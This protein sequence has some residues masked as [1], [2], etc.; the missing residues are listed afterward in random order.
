ME[1]TGRGTRQRAVWTTIDDHAAGAA[2]AFA[3]VMLKGHR[4]FTR[5]DQLFVQ[6]VEH[7]EEA[8]VLAHTVQVVGL[9]HALVVAAG[10]TP[11]VQSQFHY[12]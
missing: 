7:L 9:H 11:D 12:L 8:H 3:A 6:D 1:L 10:L 4:L 5:F 2:N